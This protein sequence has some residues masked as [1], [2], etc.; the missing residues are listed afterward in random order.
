MKKKKRQDI[1]KGFG[2]QVAGYRLR[3]KIQDKSASVAKAMT[4]KKDE[5]VELF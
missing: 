3:C 2:L 4:E 1:R 5:L